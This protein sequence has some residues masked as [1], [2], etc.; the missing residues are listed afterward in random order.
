VRGTSGII[1]D[2]GF[3]SGLD[4]ASGAGTGVSVF[5]GGLGSGLDSAFDA[6]VSVFGGGLSSCT[7]DDSG[8]GDGDGVM[9][10]S[11]ELH[12]PTT[13]KDINITVISPFC[14]CLR[15]ITQ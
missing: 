6:G 13:D 12:A 10:D 7:G 1:F 4:P 8:D 14:H 2:D 3:S 11:P 15:R 9:V 5:G